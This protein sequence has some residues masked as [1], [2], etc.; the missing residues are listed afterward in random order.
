[1]A[2][3]LG[4]A[5]RGLGNV[6][7]NP[8][9][10]CVLV[11][12]GRVIARGWT[13][14]GG[15]PH[16]E[17][18]ALR[19]AGP[20]ARGATAYVSL[21]PCAHEGQT[22][23]CAQALAEAGIARAVVALGDPDP[24]VDG[25]GVALL[26]AAGIEVDLGCLEEE[27]AELNAG[28]ILRLTAKRPLITLKTATS[29]DG[30]IA[31]KGGESRWITG[32]QARARG[33]SLR[34]SHDA[35]MIGIGTALADDPELTCRL[36]GLAERSP[37]RVVLD[38]HLRLPAGGKLVRGAG[39]VPVWVLSV[40]GGA[41]GRAD[42]LACLGVEVIEVAADDSG[43]VDLGAAL[44]VLAERGITRVLVEGGGTLAAALL[45]ARL[46][47]RVAWF[48][49]PMVIGGDGV[50]M[51]AALGVEALERAPR[52]R[53]LIVAEVGDDVLETYAVEA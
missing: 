10:G 51:A 17:A 2:A 8:A 38:S 22:G 36:P 31:T 13:Q 18:E 34:A 26:R 45:R 6:W 16:A 30:R 27:A 1:M 3:A 37:V 44:A 53:R 11:R 50:A 39:E 52:L 7:P 43:E 4:L 20:G 29:L 48:R 23:P 42:E 49:A 24:R 35:V 28:F 15:R 40:A 19:R 33:H 32:A 25:K 21:E 9:V 12:E 41:E 47:D 14:P 5:A 46:V